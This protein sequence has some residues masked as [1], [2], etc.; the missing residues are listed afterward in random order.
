MATMTPFHKFLNGLHSVQH[1]FNEE[2]DELVGFAEVMA[3]RQE[4]S[5]DLDE[6]GFFYV[7]SAG[8][9]EDVIPT[10]EHQLQR[11]KRIK[12]QKDTGH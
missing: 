8:K 1:D 2:M 4:N 10:M 9:I 6:H 12:E 7:T 3:R 5:I 11:L